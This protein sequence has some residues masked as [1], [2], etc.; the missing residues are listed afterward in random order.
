[1]VIVHWNRNVHRKRSMCISNSHVQR[2]GVEATGT[3]IG[4]VLVHHRPVD[5][6]VMR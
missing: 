3:G 6:I 2:C 1:M 5:V 4:T